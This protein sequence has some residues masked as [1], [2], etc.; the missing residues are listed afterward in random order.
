ME[1]IDLLINSRWI[2]PV[3]GEV[4][5]HE[6]HAVAVRDGRI[7]AIVPQETAAARYQAAER[8]DL[9]NHLLIPGLINAHTH[10]PMSL[11]RGYADDQPL[12]VWLQEHI[13]PA[14]QRWVSNEFVRDGSKLAIAEMIRSGTTCFNDMYFFPDSTAQ[15]AA[16]T[17]IRSVIGLIAIDFPSAWARN[18]EEYLTKG[19]EL[20]DRYRHHPLIHTAFAPHAPYTVSDPVLER[21]RTLADELECQIHIHLHE[22]EG[23]VTAAESESGIRP[24]GRLQQ[25]GLL[26]PSLTAVHMTCLD[27]SEIALLAECGANVIHCP[28]SNMKLA[29]GMAPVAALIDAGV[30]VALGTDG[31]ASNNDLDMIGEMRTAAL[32]GKAVARDAAAMPAFTLLRMATINGARALGI[33]QLTGSIEVGKMAD[34]TAVD[35]GTIETRPLYDPISQLVYASGRHQVTDVWVAGAQLLQQ[36]C[37]TTIDEESLLATAERWGELIAASHPRP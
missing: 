4:R 7:V 17:G 26:S 30:N 15:V 3:E 20:H 35:L 25:L 5:L 13:W 32:L 8:H 28:E 1:K 24:I 6:H 34:L 14:E 9:P 16:Q 31:C 19:L 11:L 18:G 22:T 37:L 27:Q 29:S 12:M 10:S 21:I 23:E 2:A 33:D 36:R